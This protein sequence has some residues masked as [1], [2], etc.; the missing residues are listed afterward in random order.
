MPNKQHSF[1]SVSIKGASIFDYEL[2]VVQV[3]TTFRFQ[4]EKNRKNSFNSMHHSTH[5]THCVAVQSAVFHICVRSLEEETGCGEV[6]SSCGSQKLS[7]VFNF[8]WQLLSLFGQ[9]ER[10]GKKQNKWENIR[11][12]GTPPHRVLLQRYA[13]LLSHSYNFP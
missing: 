4:V 9:R 11:I 6:T 5:R 7:F 3:P 12:Y 8:F 1:H 2:K 10:T 13:S